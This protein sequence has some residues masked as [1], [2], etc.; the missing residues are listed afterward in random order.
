[1]TGVTCALAIPSAEGMRCVLIKAAHSVN[2]PLTLQLPINF[3][4]SDFILLTLMNLHD[5]LTD[6]FIKTG[7]TYGAGLGGNGNLWV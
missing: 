4:P 7:C 6:T 2:D 1:M 5:S 3:L